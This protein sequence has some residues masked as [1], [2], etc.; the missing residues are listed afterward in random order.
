MSAPRH[1]LGP[2]LVERDRPSHPRV[3]VF[4]ATRVE[5]G[6]SIGEQLVYLVLW[7]N[8]RGDDNSRT[9]QIGYDKLAAMANVN[10]KTA[11]TCLR[12]LEKKLAIETI[13]KEDSIARVGRTYRIYSYVIILKRR[14]AAGLIWVEKGRGVRF[15]KTG[16]VPDSTTV[17]GFSTDPETGTASPPETGTAS[18]PDSGTL[19][20]TTEATTKEP[21]SSVVGERCRKHGVILDADAERRIVKRCRACDPAATDEEIAH[22]AEVKIGQLRGSRTVNNMVGLLI[23]GVPKFFVDPADALHHYRE[24]RAMERAEQEALARQVLD[25]P[26]STE[27]E[28]E[29]ARKVIS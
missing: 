21:S 23:T 18:V 19:S 7:R 9:I 25:D 10:W 22:F 2:D 29:W 4:R 20:G 1:A 16:T 14:N 3:R 17:P 11:R 26:Q 13:E 8:S 6:H 12:S 24:S 28:R 5:H 15:V 27:Q